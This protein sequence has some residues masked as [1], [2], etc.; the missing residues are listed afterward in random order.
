MTGYRKVRLTEGHALLPPGGSPI[1]PEHRLVLF[2][3]IGAGSHPCYRCG[4]VVEWMPGAG[5]VRGAVITDHVNRD[6]ADNSPGNLEPACVDCSLANRSNTLTDA[7]LWV[8]HGNTRVRGVLRIC[9]TCDGHFVAY[10]DRRRPR[11]GTYCSR[12][13]VWRRNAPHKDHVSSP[14]SA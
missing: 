1:V 8:R 12:D 3:K 14:G 4:T 10:V 9:P 6:R 5:A 2:E 7:D 13:C 11:A